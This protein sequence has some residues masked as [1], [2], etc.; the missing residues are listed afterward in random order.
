MA[1]LS[2]FFGIIIRMFTEHGVRHHKPHFHAVYQD[3]EA[4][5]TINPVDILSGSMPTKQQRLI[6][7]WAEI[8][9]DE[10]QAAW[11]LLDGGKKP[12]PIEPLK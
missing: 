12:H 7:A 2:R 5:F 10:L 11:D 3:Y 1:E 8:H 6:V 9:Q 4:V